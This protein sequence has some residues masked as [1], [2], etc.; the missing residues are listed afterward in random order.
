MTL[1]EINEAIEIGKLL[2]ENK[3]NWSISCNMMS[4]ANLLAGEL[5]AV[6]MYNAV[7]TLITIAEKVRDAEVP[8]KRFAGG[9]G[10]YEAI[11]YNCAID[12]LTP[13]LAKKD[14]EIE[15]LK[16]NNFIIPKGHDDKEEHRILHN[17]I[18]RDAN[19]S[20]C[21]EA[22]RIAEVIIKAGYKRK[23]LQ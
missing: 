7:Q 23:E 5:T 18:C 13:L 10:R 9:H 12:T 17:L 6:Q 15:E 11:A 21:E 22:D 8:K 16:T 2:F 14:L 1:Q 4:T 3:S 19:I 20:D